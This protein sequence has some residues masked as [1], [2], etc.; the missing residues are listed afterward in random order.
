MNKTLAVL[1]VGAGLLPGCATDFCG[2]AT[3]PWVQV[4]KS[5]FAY[6]EIVPGEVLTVQR[7][8]QGAQH[9]WAGLRARGL[10][11]GSEDI[12]EGLANDDLPWV[13]FQ[14]ES[15][16]GLHSFNTR[17]RLPLDRIEADRLF[18]LDGRP[19]QFWHWVE[20]PDDWA[21]LDMTELEEQ[22]ETEDF[23]LRV[24]IEDA[25]GDTVSDE[26]AIRLDFPPREDAARG[27][28]G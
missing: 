5:V 6:E 24:I 3:A 15:D 17:I 28:A 12:E 19:V 16:E 8:S 2:D 26:V 4:G 21:T 22:L 13:E 14:L 7:G 20:R 25:C 11:P 27:E 23:T 1:V 9:V 18:G 10:H